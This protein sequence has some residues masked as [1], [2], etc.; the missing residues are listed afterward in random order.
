MSKE[1]L[2]S[3]QFPNGGTIPLIQ[4]IFS[5]YI[6]SKDPNGYPIHFSIDLQDL[7]VGTQLATIVEEFDM[8][9]RVYLCSES[10]RV[11]HKIRKNHPNIKLVAS[12]IRK[13]VQKSTFP[14]R[15]SIYS[16]NLH[17][18]N[19]QGRNMTKELSTKIHALGYKLFIWDL[20]T[21]DSVRNGLQ[22]HPDAIYTDYP[23]IARKI[24]DDLAI[25]DNIINEND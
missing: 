8:Q 14:H 12:N 17:A 3:I 20:H 13:L 25:N 5:R 15:K 24:I 19:L 10:M 7:K 2:G 21:S 4:D 23:D 1:D 9:D 22:Y 18:I 6:K 11:F 16:L